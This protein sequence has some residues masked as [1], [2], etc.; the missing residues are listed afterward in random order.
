MRQSSAMQRQRGPMWA[1]PSVSAVAAGE[2]RRSALTAWHR[3]P[4]RAEEAPSLQGLL[5]FRRLIFRI[6]N[7][8]KDL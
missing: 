5:L 7:K 1:W 6:I 4:Q 8:V 3:I 2:P